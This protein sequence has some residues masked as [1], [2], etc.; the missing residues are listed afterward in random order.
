M[1]ESTGFHSAPDHASTHH[2]RVGV[3]GLQA[4]DRRPQR[5]ARL[6]ERRVW[7]RPR[8]ELDDA[9]AL[10]AQQRGQRGAVV[11]SAVH[12]QQVLRPP[13]V[14]GGRDAVPLQRPVL[15]RPVR[16]PVQQAVVQASVPPDPASHKVAERGGGGADDVSQREG[17]RPAVCV[18]PPA[19]AGQAPRVEARR[20]GG[21]EAAALEG[22]G[23][24]EARDWHRAGLHGEARRREGDAGQ[25]AAG[26]VGLHGRPLVPCRH[27][28][29]RRLEGDEARAPV[30]RPSRVRVAVL[31]RRVVVARRLPVR[32]LHPARV[33]EVARRRRAGEGERDDGLRAHVGPLHDE[34]G[35][36][37]ARRGGDGLLDG[38][39]RG[40]RGERR[41][42]GAGGRGPICAARLRAAI[43]VC[44]LGTPRTR[45]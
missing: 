40:G 16:R 31:L 12:K 13:A 29:R 44:C 23:L 3:P 43:P 36:A 27:L 39:L 45:R 21:G 41:G 6:C 11:H 17:G 14:E 1:C 7:L 8:E 15:R 34:V 24:Q 33:R 42:G 30:R 22:G 35:A 25:A 2:Q 38:R 4:A 32:P 28:V 20:R 9:G 26:D 18:W 19:E 10:S 5:T 37:Q